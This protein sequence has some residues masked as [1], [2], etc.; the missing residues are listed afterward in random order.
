MTVHCESVPE[1]TSRSAGIEPA[2]EL[3]GA[4]GD[5]A[6]LIAGFLTSRAPAT[7]GPKASALTG[8]A[9]LTAVRAPAPQL[10][11]HVRDAVS[12]GATHDEVV[13]TIVE[14]AA[15]AGLEAAFSVFIE[16]DAKLAKAS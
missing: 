4:L 15:H 7:L 14:A 2:H 16:T 3:H 11:A 1:T 12:A 5:E 10:R 13:A 9:A 8:L 6:H